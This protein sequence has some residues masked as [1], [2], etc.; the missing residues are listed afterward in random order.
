MAMLIPIVEHDVARGLATKSW[1]DDRFYIYESSL[2]NN[3][4]EF[5][6]SIRNSPVSEILVLCV[7][8]PSVGNPVEQI[9]RP[10][11]RLADFRLTQTKRFPILVHS[12]QD[13]RHQSP[14]I[15]KILEGWPCRLASPVI[16]IEDVANLWYPAFRGLLRDNAGHDR[17]PVGE[18]TGYA[19]SLAGEA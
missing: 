17:L 8:L 10:L 7:G 12:E 19:Q 16:G 5:F 3:L 2:Y 14:R 6:K 18:S 4:L 9:E 15:S 13:L 11:E 1:I